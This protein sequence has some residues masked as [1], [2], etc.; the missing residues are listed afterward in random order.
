ML[1]CDNG[2]YYTGYTT[3][4]D[5]RFKMHKTGKG[6]KYTRAHKPKAIVY[7][8]E[9]KTKSEA[10]KRECAIKKLTHKEKEELVNA[11]R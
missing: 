10:I 8:E 7:I 11:S 3:D 4:V 1:L 6:A 2:A 5:R 9:F